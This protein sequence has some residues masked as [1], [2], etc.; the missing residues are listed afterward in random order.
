MSSIPSITKASLQMPNGDLPLY[1]P[2]DIHHTSLCT[3]TQPTSSSSHHTSTHPHIT[4]SLPQQDCTTPSESIPTTTQHTHLPNMPTPCPTH[5]HHTPTSQSTSY[6]THAHSHNYPPHP[7][8]L[9]HLQQSSMTTQP[10]SIQERLPISCCS[11]P[12]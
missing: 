3:I 5:E 4:P 6:I 8:T 10:H 7:P 11:P 2:H 1:T 12:P 9:L